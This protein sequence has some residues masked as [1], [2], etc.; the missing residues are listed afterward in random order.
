MFYLRGRLY[1]YYKR[2]GIAGENVYPIDHL[3][4]GMLGSHADPNLKS[5]ASEARC[6]LGFAHDI[7]LQF[8]HGFGASGPFLL[9]AVNALMLHYELLAT[10]DRVLNHESRIGL[11]DSCKECVMAFKAAGGHLTPKFHLWVQ[12]KQTF[13]VR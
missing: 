4:L 7:L 13:D 2:K 10:N 5:K 1:T 11:F 12:G 8:I 9:K 6:V 3:T